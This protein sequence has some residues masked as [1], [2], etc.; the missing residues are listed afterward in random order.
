MR[1][2]IIADN[3]KSF[4]DDISARILINDD[5]PFSIRT[6]NTVA[7]IDA[8][9]NEQPADMIAI[10]DNLII[11]GI[12]H[13]AQLAA[14]YQ[15]K[16]Y[17][18]CTSASGMERF[19]AIGI[20]CLGLLQKTDKLLDALTAII[21]A[22]PQGNA[23]PQ[24]PYQAQHTQP[25]LQPQQY[26]QPQNVA[27]PYEPQQVYAPYNAANQPANIAQQT[28]QPV[29][30]YVQ[31][32]YQGTAASYPPQQ[33]YVPPSQVVAAQAPQPVYPQQA[34]SPAPYAQQ[35][36]YAVPAAER[37]YAAPAVESIR[38]NRQMQLNREADLLLEKDGIFEDKSNQTKVITV[39]AA[40]GGVG[41]TTI[42][43]Q[44]AVYLAL[45]SDGRR[46]FNVCLVD[47]NID[48]G[49]I[50]T[51]L[52]LSPKGVNMTHW[53]ADIQ[54]QI[55]ARIKM[56]YPNESEAYHE[57]VFDGIKAQNDPNNIV[58]SI[59]YEKSDI[60]HTW[61]QQM[62]D[63]G[64]YVLV[65][66]TH[67]EDSMNI[68]VPDLQTMLRNLI[69]NGDFDFVICDTGNNTRSSSI[70]ALQMSDYTFLVATQDITTVNC[71]DSFLGTM[72]KLAPMGLGFDLNRIR[73]VINNILPF[74]S[75]GLTI[76]E[77]EDNF[78]FPC[79]ARIKRS[80]DV[81][82]ANNLGKPIVYNEKH[83][84]T[85]EI[86]NIVRYVTGKGL[87]MPEAEPEKKKKKK[88]SLF[89]KKGD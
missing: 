63:T 80:E 25:Q 41:K 5:L 69:D 2:I 57:Q 86:Q 40:K 23:Q 82:K 24:Q 71:N 58:S 43:S 56:T 61:L 76:K 87:V 18:Y 14:L 88:F 74:Q 34:G 55:M 30:Q 65:A 29:Q 28:Y 44:L 26:Q 16:I 22:V 52:N 20:P 75:T 35:G 62:P 72:R 53:S 45:T 84:F 77:I 54:E 10:S 50:A 9:A 31:P 67:H 21:D 39:Y 42:A 4:A 81:I 33:A 66:P 6:T 46:K 1:S 47:F 38:N 48:F 8:L 85:K 37:Q 60:R 49:D 59:N 51:T 89:S 15:N 32:Q 70:I 78:D 27:A 36:Q 79:V 19:S 17:G 13:I 3:R 83:N 7:S 73:L 11:D 68:E 64:L 12:K